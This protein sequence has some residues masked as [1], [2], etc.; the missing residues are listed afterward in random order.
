MI[1]HLPH[2]SSLSAWVLPYLPSYVFLL[3]FGWQLSLLGAAFP[4]G[5]SSFP[6]GQLAV[7]T[8]PIGVSTFRMIEMRSG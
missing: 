3:P 6:H 2:V 8:D 4:T 1:T 5:E 7:L